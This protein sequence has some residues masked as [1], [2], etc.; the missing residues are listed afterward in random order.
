MKAS[1][2]IPCYNGGDLLPRCID[3]CLSQDVDFEF[4]IIAI[5]SS[6]TD[7]SH[8]YLAKKSGGDPRIR[9][10][11]I[12]KK[13]F[14]HGKTRNFGASQAKGELLCYL[15]QDAIPANRYWLANLVNAMDRHPEAAGAF[16]R[17]IA[18]PGHSP[19]TKQQ[20]DLHFNSFG[21]GTVAYRMESIERYET[22]T[23]YRQR[24][25]YYSDNNS[26]M[27][28]SVWLAHPYDDVPFGEDQIWADK[29]I[30]L[31]FT[32]LYV[33]DAVVFHS[34]EF[35]IRESY[36][37][38]CEEGE[39]FAAHFGYILKKSS[40]SVFRTTNY[41]T[42]NEYRFHLEQSGYSRSV[43]K[44]PAIFLRNIAAQWGHYRGAKN[45]RI[46]AKKK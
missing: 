43:L 22:D 14:G 1:I 11:V 12:D 8:E 25:H 20:L 42:G 28:R 34:H 24:L 23:G 16:G 29:I 40:W 6:S 30:R 36:I 19:Y 44:L 3:Q 7:G 41:I 26:C 2:I 32:K 35:G 5:D 31:G 15:T 9:M 21:P 18:H 17:H 4:E 45:A 37:R 10:F 13:Q 38:G 39:F 27:R 33:D 46:D